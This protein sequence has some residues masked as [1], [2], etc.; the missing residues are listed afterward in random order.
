MEIDGSQKKPAPGRLIL[1]AGLLTLFL[2]AGGCATT[3]GVSIPDF[4]ARGFPGSTGPLSVSITAA[5]NIDDLVT[6]VLLYVEIANAYYESGNAAASAHVIDHAIRLINVGGVTDP[7]VLAR[8][9]ELFFQLDR[10]EPGLI[11]LEK[12]LDAALLVSNEWAR[13]EALRAVIGAI[14]VASDA[15]F[16]FQR[17]TIESIFVIEDLTTRFGLLIDVSDMYRRAGATG[18]ANMLLQQAIPAVGALPDKWRRADA[19]SR[20]AQQFQL[21]GNA[22]SADDYLRRSLSEL[23]SPDPSPIGDDDRL[24][25]LDISTRFFVL[26]RQFDASSVLDATGDRHLVARGLA[27]HAE[28]FGAAGDIPS[29]YI[30]LS[31]AG[32]AAEQVPDGFLRADAHA[33]ISAA[34]SAIGDVQ[35]ARIHA[36]AA[37]IAMNGVSDQLKIA[38]VFERLAAVID[39]GDARR[40]VAEFADPTIG[41]RILAGA[42]IARLDA[43]PE[44]AAELLADAAEAALESTLSRDAVLGRIAVALS[45]A[46]RFVDAMGLLVEISSPV[47]QVESLIR[48]ARDGGFRDEFDE[49][50]TAIVEAVSATIRRR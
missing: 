45:A 17:R 27:A 25:V 30:F 5:E 2:L 31:R 24:M 48:I 14:F 47:V 16:E 35:L 37:E 4:P 38:S 22:S 12:A 9:A 32:S 29:A 21:L 1:F 6:R 20:I 46:G 26:G 36:S 42:G 19:Y 13:G 28:L 50:E 40:L 23:R 7:V 39:P 49:S 11:H 8:V 41:A 34:Y 33:E 43:E 15:A 18:N 3:A 44:D 10:I